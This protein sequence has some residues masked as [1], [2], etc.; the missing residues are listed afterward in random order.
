MSSVDDRHE[1]PQGANDE[2]VAAAGKLSEALE[3]V[4]RA[5][6]R[7]Y[8]CHQL[9]GR[10]D[11]LF[12]EAADRLACA[13]HPRWADPIRSEVVGRNV[14][15]G[16]WTF[17]VVEEFDDLYWQCVR[18][19]ESAIRHAL[20]SGRRHLFEAQL[21]QARRTHG[22]RFHEARPADVGA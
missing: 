14:V 19:V 2:V 1:R 18:D 22:R 8:D 13:G 21:K 4:E 20:V 5:R 7:L 12:E 15:D 16:R 11:F 17:Q 3:W 6:G 9:V 10:A